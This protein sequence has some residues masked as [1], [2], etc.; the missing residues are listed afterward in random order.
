MRTP[1]GRSA[2]HRCV[3]C[4]WASLAAEIVEAGGSPLQPGLGRSLNTPL[5]LAARRGHPQLMKVLVPSS[6]VRVCL[7]RLLNRPPLSS[8]AFC[9]P[10]FKSAETCCPSLVTIPTPAL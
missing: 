7:H 9:R 8:P 3:E 6:A 10:P 5:H 4:G 2:L 1:D